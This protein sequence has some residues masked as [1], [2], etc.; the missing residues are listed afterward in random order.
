MVTPVCLSDY[1]MDNN[2]VFPTYKF[3]EIVNKGYDKSVS[4]FCLY[5]HLQPLPLK[6]IANTNKTGLQAVSRPVEHIL[7][8]F[9]E[10]KNLPKK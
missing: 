1:N 9:Q 10:L 7:V 2:K 5:I 3:N 8:F 4:F 6:L